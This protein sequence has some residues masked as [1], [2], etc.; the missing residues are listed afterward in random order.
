MQDKGPNATDNDIL[1]EY[2]LT[3]LPLALRNK[4]EENILSQEITNGI[5]SLHNIMEMP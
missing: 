2:Y 1:I 5:R 3:T 4:I